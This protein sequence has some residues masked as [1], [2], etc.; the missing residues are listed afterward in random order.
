MM[1]QQLDSGLEGGRSQNPEGLLNY[2]ESVMFSTKSSK[3]GLYDCLRPESF[4]MGSSMSIACTPAIGVE[5]SK[6]KLP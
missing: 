3:R 1:P 4:D 5:V 2:G 6:V